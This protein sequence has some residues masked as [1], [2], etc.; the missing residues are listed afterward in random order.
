MGDSQ[1]VSELEQG[2]IGI[3]MCVGKVARMGAWLHS[4]GQIT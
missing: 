1:G 4:R 3:Y 2:E